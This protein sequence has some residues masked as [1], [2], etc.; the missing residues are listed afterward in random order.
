[1]N[2][3]LPF[4]IKY[5]SVVAC[6]DDCERTWIAHLRE[7]DYDTYLKDKKGIC[8]YCNSINVMYCARCNQES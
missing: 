2:N 4:K 3:I 7:R 5:V 8:C 1:M 6:C